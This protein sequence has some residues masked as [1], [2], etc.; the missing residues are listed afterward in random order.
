MN[1]ESTNRKKEKGILEQEYQNRRNE[2]KRRDSAGISIFWVE[3]E[4][5]S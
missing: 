5:T 1:R 3:A 4:I 2:K